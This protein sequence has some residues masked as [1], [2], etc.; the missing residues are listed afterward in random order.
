[1]NSNNTKIHEASISQYLYV[2]LQFICL[3]F[4]VRNEVGYILGIVAVV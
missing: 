2:N 3:Y 1:M 4:G